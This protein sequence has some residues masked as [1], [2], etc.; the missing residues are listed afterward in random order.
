MYKDLEYFKYLE[1]RWNSDKDVELRMEREVNFKAVV[2]AIR[3][4]GLVA[5]RANHSK[6]H[7]GQKTFVINMN[8]YTYCVPFIEEKEYIFLKTIFPSRK[9]HK[10]HAIRE[11]SH[12]KI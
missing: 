1:Y 8:D 2:Q 7:L 11:S 9:L 10:K 4:G 3:N 6:Q 12:Q 5:I